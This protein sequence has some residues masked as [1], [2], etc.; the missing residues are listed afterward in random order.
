[1]SVDLVTHRE[2]VPVRDNKGRISSVLEHEWPEPR[3]VHEKHRAAVDDLHAPLIAELRDRMDRLESE[4]DALRETVVKQ[5]GELD[6]RE[7]QIADVQERLRIAIA[8]ATELTLSGKARP[9]LATWI[10]PEPHEDETAG[11]YLASLAT[12]E[13]DQDELNTELEARRIYWVL[14]GSR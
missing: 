7:A 2:R 10:L 12:I 3:A 8:T 9:S 11:A 13:R 1:M 5:R 4:R 6:G 14:G